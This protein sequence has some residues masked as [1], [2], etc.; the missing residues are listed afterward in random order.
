MA[1][2]HD[3]FDYLDSEHERLSKA[4]RAAENAYWDAKSK[5]RTDAWRRADK[6]KPGPEADEV[7]HGPVVTPEK[8]AALEKSI[9][10][11]EALAT[12]VGPRMCYYPAYHIEQE[13]HRLKLEKAKMVMRGRYEAFRNMSDATKDEI[14]AE[15]SAG[16]VTDVAL[17]RK[18]GVTQPHIVKILAQ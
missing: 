1:S 9:A 6:M 13:I 11:D 17:A 12:Y 10:A 14:R 18:Y 7:R 5:A 4:A 3:R 16:G 2:K 15:F 8:T